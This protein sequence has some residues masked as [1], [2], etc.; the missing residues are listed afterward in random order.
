MDRRVWVAA[1]ALLLVVTF[2]AVLAFTGEEADATPL[3]YGVDWSIDQGPSTVR[4]DELEEGRNDTYTFELERANLT[5]VSINL[6]W[7]DDVGEP[8][9][10]SLWVAPPEGEPKTN[11][12]SNETVTLRFPIQD[13]PALDTVEALDREEARTRL[14]EEASTDGQ[15]TWRVRVTLEEA[16]GRRPIPQAPSLETQPDGAN[17]YEVTFGHQAFFSDLGD[18]TPP[19]RA[20]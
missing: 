2:G 13:P 14:N 7:E 20:G 9:R 17:S 11:T 12:S 19:D 16:P 5:T 15:G 10:F 6:S 18:P 1:I 3:A 4:E 8:D